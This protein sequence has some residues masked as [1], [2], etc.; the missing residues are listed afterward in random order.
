M[1]G[2]FQFFGALWQG[3]LSQS[4]INQFVIAATLLM[5]GLGWIWTALRVRD[6]TGRIRNLERENAAL[7]KERDLARK[8]AETECAHADLF[9]PE[10]WLEAAERETAQGNHESA[11]LALQTGFENAAPDLARVAK[12][13]GEHRV[14]IMAER[15]AASA[16]DDATRFTR[17]SLLLDPTD[18]E[19]SKLI[20]EISFA[21]AEAGEAVPEEDLVRT[22][23]PTDPQ[24]AAELIQTIY[25]CGKVLFDRGSYL[26]A[27]RMFARGVLVADRAQLSESPDSLAVRLL[28]AMAQ[29]R[30]GRKAGVL[31]RVRALLPIFA[32]VLG[33]E[34]SN[35]LVAR[36]VEVELM[37]KEGDPK[38]ALEKVRA[39]IPVHERVQGNEHSDVLFSRYLEAELMAALE[40][41]AGA[42]EKVRLLLPVYDRV[43]GANHRLTMQPRYLEAQLMLES[44]DYTGALEKL[45]VL[46]PVRERVQGKD[47][48]DVLATR[49]L[50]AKALAELGDAEAALVEW[51]TILPMQEARLLGAHPNVNSTR[52]MIAKYSGGAEE[53]LTAP[54]EAD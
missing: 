33:E 24:E 43:R 6:N 39:L 4:T 17:L 9:I 45:R 15:N 1:D 41:T 53:A 18:A 7:A 2:L 22:A 36:S 27:W 21:R 50:K 25:K 26:L 44:G 11:I 23:L 40:D 31:K 32:R 3:W 46:L 12:K 37:S 47:H 20:E 16:L 51:R 5:P 34:H 8:E 42:L 19:A 13:L 29:S 54:D 14:S 52:E 10:R 30:S 28:E 35:M 48:P 38:A 49:Y